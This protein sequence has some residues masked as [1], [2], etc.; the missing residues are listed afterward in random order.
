MYL[1]SC[2]RILGA[3]YSTGHNDSCQLGDKCRREQEISTLIYTGVDF[4]DNKGK[5]KLEDKIT[6]GLMFFK[7]KTGKLLLPVLQS[8]FCMFFFHFG[9]ALTHSIFG[10]F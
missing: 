2:E 4:C 5:T 3:D 8:F 7:Q 6:C 9:G 10:V 1:P